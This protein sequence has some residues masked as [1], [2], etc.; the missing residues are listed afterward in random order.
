[1]GT[2]VL[3]FI[4]VPLLV[5]FLYFIGFNLD[6]DTTKRVPLSGSS[7]PTSY[8]RD[9]GNA[10][11]DPEELNA[12]MREFYQRTGVAPFLYIMPKDSSIHWSIA[13]TYGS[14]YGPTLPQK[15]R[16]F[17][18][19]VYS[20]QSEGGYDIDIDV[21]Y[22]AQ[23]VMDAAAIQAFERALYAEHLEP[24]ATLTKAF[25]NAYRDSAHEIMEQEVEDPIKSVRIVFS[26]IGIAA[27]ISALI[28]AS[29][30]RRHN[31]EQRERERQEYIEKV[32]EMPLEKF[33]DAEMEELARKYEQTD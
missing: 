25:I 8:F 17:F 20:A 3:S 24:D 28:C 1:M 30:I 19:V 9:A 14:L 13:A 12:A 31:K 5:L 2:I 33:E 23:D 27:L 10:I 16:T 21:G 22:K 6:P 18:T 4:T 32:L 11:R 15:N 7:T 29:L 26:G